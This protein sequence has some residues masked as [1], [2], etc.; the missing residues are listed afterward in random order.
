MISS[1]MSKSCELSDPLPA[2][3]FKV[4]I[5]VQ[6]PVITTIVNMSIDQVVVPDALK[7]ALL[8][9]LLKRANLEPEHFPNF[10]LMFISKLC[11]RVV[12]TRLIKYLY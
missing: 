12:A 9:P 1:T 11:E 5:D 2:S 8:K 6:L 10:F 3:V 4:T 7:E